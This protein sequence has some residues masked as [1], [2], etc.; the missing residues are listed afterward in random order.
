M[1]LCRAAQRAVCGWQPH[2]H[3]HR[4]NA[5]DNCR[6]SP[7]A[8]QLDSDGDQVG[9]ACDN[10]IATANTAQTDVDGDGTLD[11]YVTHYRTDDIRDRGQVDLQKQN[12]T[13]IVPPPLQNRLLVV[14]G[15]VQEYGEP[16]LLYL[17]QGGG[18]F[19]PV[20]G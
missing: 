19:K 3:A 5:C 8:S 10:C 14:N 1:P 9:N 20:S 12:G 16:D 7:N 6:C 4:R 17:N 13:L 15:K 11:L 18:R 2:A